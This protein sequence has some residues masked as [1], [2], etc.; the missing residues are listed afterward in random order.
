VMTNEPSG[1]TSGTGTEDAP[2]SP[3]GGSRSGDVSTLG[4][5]ARWGRSGLMVAIVAVVLLADQ[6]AKTWAETHLTI[7][8]RHE[9]GPFDL[10]LRFN[11]GAAFGI[12]RGMAPLVALI[13]VAVVVFLFG[14][15]KPSQSLLGTFASGLLVGGA[16][17]NLADRVFRSNGGAVIDWIHFPHWPTFNLADSSIVAG[18]ALLLIYNLRQR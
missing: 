15:I 13:G 8:P 11:T 7:F 6:S 3:S 4:S 10:R 14:L 5:R 16:V 12:G 1:L 18:V 17:S 2:A 9:F